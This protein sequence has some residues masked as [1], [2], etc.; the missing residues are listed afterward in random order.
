ML[1][2]L[3]LPYLTLVSD[4]AVSWAC[5]VVNCVP[6]VMAAAASVEQFGIA[7][8]SISGWPKWAI[9]AKKS[10]RTIQYFR[11]L[12][13]GKNMDRH[14]TITGLDDHSVDCSKNRDG[15]VFHI[16]VTNQRCV[17]QHTYNYVLREV[18]DGT[19]T[20]CVEKEQ[21][22]HQAVTRK[23]LLVWILNASTETPC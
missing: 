12:S 11:S 9:C 18:Y 5:T 17:S 7:P 4:R 14:A 23:T 20:Q 6:L 21:H 16:Y 2:L 22:S 1:L 8:K 15:I 3:L 13:R 10:C 19:A